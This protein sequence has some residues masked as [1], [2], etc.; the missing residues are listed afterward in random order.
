LAT[1]PPS[2]A[3]VLSLEEHVREYAFL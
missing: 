1:H 3:F 2:A